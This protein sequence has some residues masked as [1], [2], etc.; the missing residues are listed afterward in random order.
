MMNGARPFRTGRVQIARGT[1]ATE[2]SACNF[3]DLRRLTD[4]CAAPDA[5]VRMRSVVCVP[6]TFPLHI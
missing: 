6:Y 5:L 2:R 3:R 4:R 1:R